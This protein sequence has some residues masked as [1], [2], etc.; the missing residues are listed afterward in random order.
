M[1]LVQSPVSTMSSTSTPREAAVDL[2]HEL[3]PAD[4]GDVK[5]VNTM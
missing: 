3:R 1:Y 4:E 2:I 5:L